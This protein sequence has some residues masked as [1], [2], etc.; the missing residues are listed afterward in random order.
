M[1]DKIYITGH[2]NPDTDSICS[3]IAYAY[4]KNRLDIAA[5]PVRIGRINRETAFVLDYFGVAQ[6]EYLPT[7]K[8]QA[9]NLNMDV[10]DPVSKQLSLREAWQ[11]LKENKMS[12]LPVEDEDHKLCGIVSISDIAN[13]YMNMPESN[14]LS[15]S[16]TPLDNVLRTL[17]AELV[18]DSGKSL[19]ESG[20]VVVAAT[21][22]DGLEFY[23]GKGDIVLVGD[24]KDN[25]I[26][27]I[28]V[29]VSCIIITC[30]SEA[31]EDII[32]EAK[33][34]GC[35]ILRT[36]Y[37]T[38]TAARLIYQSIPV[39][40]F[41]TSKNLVCFRQDD[42]IDVIR[43][44]MLQTRFRNYPVIDNLGRFSGFISRYHLINQ[45][46][47]KVILV[48]HNER[49][50]TINGIDQAE[51]MEIIDH[52]RIGDIQTG[53]P[54]YYRNEPVG[55]TAT[56]VAN[57]FFENGMMPPPEIAGIL[58]AAILS[59]TVIFKSP[60]S[61]RIDIEAANKLSKISG[62]DQEAFAKQ[63]F[64]AGSS[65]KNMPP[66]EIIRN[67]FKEYLIGS[68]KIG[69]GQINT[70]DMHGIKKFRSSV[71]SYMNELVSSGELYVVLLIISD[72]I[73]EETEV[74]FVETQK[75]MVAKAFNPLNDESS[76]TIKGVVSRK[77]QIV[78]KLTQALSSY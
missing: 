8:A 78:P 33:E 65:L 29:G 34:K 31:D 56:I 5:V 23:M 68:R 48:D 60:T 6:P 66:D 11:I 24:R 47:K 57:L 16:Q 10:I 45:N 59:D 71:L 4:L 18:Y 63:M 25:Q 74:L 14:T 26:K 55:S 40:F 37:D 12:V 39:S 58:C 69:I 21:K 54:I 28:A 3:S 67:D 27:A 17:Y 2:Q 15:Q 75:G 52:H 70:A 62:I 44:K 1:V 50:Q 64:E 76:F 13:A 30:G 43:E 20:K 35:T 32:E 49:S 36:E 7:V 38:F 19:F 41:M 73:N 9:S 53:N 42:Y 77:K 22:P 72:I 51:I 61:T 46:R